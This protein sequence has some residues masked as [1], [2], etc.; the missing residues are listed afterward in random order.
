[1]A[2]AAVAAAVCIILYWRKRR[3]KPGTMN[4]SGALD[5]ERGPKIEP[6]L[7][8]S[9]TTSQGSSVPPRLWHGAPDSPGGIVVGATQIPRTVS[10]KGA[11]QQAAVVHQSP[12][13][14]TPTAL[15][16]RSESA[17]PSHDSDAPPAYS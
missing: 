1:M 5:E 6:F 11:M 9:P 15:A 13:E 3:G 2:F 14:A 12:P 10:R 4:R 7:P 16:A 8:A 17:W